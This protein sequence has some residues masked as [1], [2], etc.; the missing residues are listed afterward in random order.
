[1]N[2]EVEM[3][4]LFVCVKG[5]FL[6]SWGPG[7]QFTSSLLGHVREW[8]LTGEALGAVLLE[9][10]WGVGSASEGQQPLAGRSSLCISALPSGPSGSRLGRVGWTWA[11]DLD[12]SCTSMGCSSLTCKTGIRLL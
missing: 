8:E 7:G 11:G 6:G 4:G 2:S 5:S 9:G 10:R 12:P 3:R 1:M